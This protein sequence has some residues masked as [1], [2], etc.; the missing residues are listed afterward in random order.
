MDKDIFE[1][2]VEEAGADEL[3]A[4]L[5]AV[6]DQLAAAE[7]AAA[8]AREELLRRAADLDNARKRYARDYERAC[9]AASR[10]V[11]EKLLP[12]LADLTRTV[13]AAG[14][15]EAIPA[16]FVDALRM[17]ERKIFDA[18][19]A[20]GLQPILA[21]R[22]VPFDPEVH[23][24]VIAAC[25]PALAPGVIISVLEPGYTFQGA[26]LKP[27]RVEVCVAPAAPAED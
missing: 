19:A 10:G 1:I 15:D 22:G 23:E 26:L 20:E 27:A 13:D 3:K 11:V 16:H 2:P 12:L 14:R 24:A 6:E 25:D 18:L 21:A 8:A 9:A 4:R 17:W 7:A 5:A